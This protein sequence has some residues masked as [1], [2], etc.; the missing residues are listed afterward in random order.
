[1]VAGDAARMVNPL[2][3]GGIHA[4]MSSGKLAADYRRGSA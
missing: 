3:G 2:S 4:A 1:M